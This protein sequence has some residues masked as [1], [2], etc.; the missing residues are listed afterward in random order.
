MLENMDYI[1]VPEDAWKK[2]IKWYSLQNGQVWT[3]DVSIRCME[4][5]CQ[6]LKYLCLMVIVCCHTL[7]LFYHVKD[8]ILVLFC[9]SFS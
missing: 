7:G 8:F 5:H 6:I 9:F 2:L 4:D 1:L 3:L